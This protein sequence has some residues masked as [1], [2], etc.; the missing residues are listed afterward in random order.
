MRISEAFPSKYLEG[1]TLDGDLSL[2][3][4]HVEME[5]VGQGD[6]V[7][8]KPVVYFNEV[9]KGL[10]LNKTNANTVSHLHGDDTEDWIGKRITIFPTEVDFQ[11][12]QVMAIRVRLRA[13]GGNGAAVKQAGSKLTPDVAKGQAWL[14]F[15]ESNPGENATVL[16][17][18]FGNAAKRYFNCDDFAI[19][20][21]AQWQKFAADNFEKPLDEAAAEILGGE[22]VDT[23]DLPF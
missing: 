4:K 15:K 23:S 19:L 17:P 7:D 8:T 5:T 2:T 3:I 21:A 22:E 11:G 13:P 10:I 20:T 9:N 12:K 16:G 6:D 14:K 1:K 18:K